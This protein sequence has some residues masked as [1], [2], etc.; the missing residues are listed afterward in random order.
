MSGSR[1]AASARRAAAAPCRRSIS[2]V[3]NPSRKSSMGSDSLSARVDPLGEAREKLPKSELLHRVA[4][5]GADGAGGHHVPPFGEDLIV[6]NE[7]GSRAKR[8]AGS[9]TILPAGAESSVVRAALSMRS[10]RGTSITSNAKARAQS[11]STRE[12]P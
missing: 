9:G 11:A 2:S 10:M 1:P 3:N 8:L 6:A 5:L 7:A 4:R 12:A